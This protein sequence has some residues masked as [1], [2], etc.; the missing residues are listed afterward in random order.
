MNAALQ[1]VNP[2]KPGVCLHP[3]ATT[4]RRPAVTALV[5]RALRAAGH[6]AKLKEIS[7]G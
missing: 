4:L 5:A 6:P 7:N 2:I 1:P 3:P